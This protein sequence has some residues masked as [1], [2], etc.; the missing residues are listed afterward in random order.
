MIS[1]SENQWLNSDIFS[2]WFVNLSR[3]EMGPELNTVIHFHKKSF[4]KLHT[5]LNEFLKKT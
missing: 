4:I 2:F 5:I 3:L 1:A